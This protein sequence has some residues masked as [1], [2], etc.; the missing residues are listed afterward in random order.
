MMPPL[1][2]AT[3]RLRTSAVA[4][5]VFVVACGG[6][7]A[8]GT[9]STDGAGGST[10]ADAASGGGGSAAGTGGFVATGGA[11][12]GGTTSD[13]VSIT[14]TVT[15]QGSYC[16]HGCTWPSIHVMDS[17]GH[18]LDFGTLCSVDCDTCGST[19][20]P[21]LPCFPDDLVT[22]ATLEWDG[23]YYVPS[24]C[25]PGTSCFQRTFATPGRYT[26]TFCETPGTLSGPDGGY[27]ECVPSGPEKCGEVAFDYPSSSAVHGTLGP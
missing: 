18:P 10:S 20:C 25:G 11:G 7:T 5:L 8:G 14:F 3:A 27:R 17:G 2:Y 13:T 1:P 6:S 12:T 24:A 23:S 26:A 16:H 4:A 22:E 21:P 15:G 19:L 9:G